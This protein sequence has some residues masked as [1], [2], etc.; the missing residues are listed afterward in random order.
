MESIQS[1]YISSFHEPG[2]AGADAGVSE[3][4]LSLIMLGAAELLCEGFERSHRSRC[5]ELMEPTIL[6]EKKKE[7]YSG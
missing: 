6:V 5:R 1:S 3:N 7:P 2:A 4:A